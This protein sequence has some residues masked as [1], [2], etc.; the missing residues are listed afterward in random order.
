MEL[1]VELVRETQGLEEDGDHRSLVP[2]N[3]YFLE[4]QRNL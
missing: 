3:R 1:D 2:L 4:G